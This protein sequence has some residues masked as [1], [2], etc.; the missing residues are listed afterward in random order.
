MRVPLSMEKPECLQDNSVRANSRLSSP[1]FKKRATTLCLQASLS[2]APAR[3]CREITVEPTECFERSVRIDR[4]PPRIYASP[5]W[6]HLVF[7]FYILCLLSGGAV[8]SI[9]VLYFIRTKNRTLLAYIVLYSLLSLK[10]LS[11]IVDA[12]AQ[13][14]G[15]AIPD[16]L[17]YPLFEFS[18]FS[19]VWALPMF[20]NSFF[21]APFGRVVNIAFAV[22]AG[23]F[24]TSDA[25]RWVSGKPRDASDLSTAIFGS[26]LLAAIAYSIIIGFVFRRRLER[27]LQKKVANGMIVMFVAFLPGF[28]IDSLPIA[29]TSF[30]F[31]SVSYLLWNAGTLIFAARSIVPLQGKAPID[32]RVLER[33][34]LT[35]R[36]AEVLDRLSKGLSYKEIADE[37]YV[38]FA[39]VKTHIHNIYFKTGTKSRH[40]LFAVLGRYPEG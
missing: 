28:I 20:F 34:D 26:V 5:V 40:A 16:V 31:S 38:S 1:L 3:E 6:Q 15:L 8:L 4:P 32:P 10:I 37:M 11:W 22:T 14:L 21:D 2:S 13:S 23:A 18:I 33:F 27:P 19:I 12:Y 9:A 7:F 17:Y 39:T 30:I 24:I 36:E 29:A 25:L 35:R